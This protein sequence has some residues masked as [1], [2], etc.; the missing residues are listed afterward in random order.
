MGS[1]PRT[2]LR[3]GGGC[4]SNHWHVNPNH[5]NIDSD[6]ISYRRKLILVRYS[7]EPDVL[8]GESIVLV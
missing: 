3:W 4:V 2:S 8:E 6:R 7:I 5:S 1:A